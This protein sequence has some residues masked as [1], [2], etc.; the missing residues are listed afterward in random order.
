MLRVSNTLR[1]AAGRG[2][3]GAAA[4]LRSAMLEACAGIGF[5]VGRAGVRGVAVKESISGGAAGT[6]PCSGH[7]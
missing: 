3:G 7:S 4:A 5:G 1:V 6:G 2:G